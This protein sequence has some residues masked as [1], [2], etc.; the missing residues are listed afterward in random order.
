MATNM[1]DCGERRNTNKGVKE[2]KERRWR[3]EGIIMII[4][5][6][7]LI[8]LIRTVPEQHTGRVRN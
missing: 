4:I 6:I 1:F 3:S 7:I 8:V 5:I 2:N